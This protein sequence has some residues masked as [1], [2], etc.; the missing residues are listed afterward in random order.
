[1]NELL[2]KL[3]KQQREAVEYING[4]LL[5]LAGAGSGK[6]RVLTHRI[7]YMIGG[8]GVSPWNILAITFTNKAA[9]EMAQ[10]V[11]ALVGAAVNDMWVR[12]FHSAC[13]RILRRD[14]D[15][16]GYDTRFNIIDSDDQKSLVKE[17]I[18]EL[19]FD[20][21]QFPPRSVMSEI[22]FAK[23]NLAEPEAYA[24]EYGEDYRKK[25]IARIYMLYQ[26]KLKTA[27]DLD[28]DDL[29]ML[30]VKL[31]R[32]NEDVLEF[33]RNKFRYILVDEYQD[34]NKA[35]NELVML[36]AGEHRNLCVVGDDDQSIY[37][38]RGADISN[39]L[40]FEK[41]FSESRTVRLEQN[42]RSTQNILDAAN[43]VIKNN[44]G[45]KGKKL[46]TDKGE[47][48]KI[49]VYK[50]LN[51]HDEA[52]F[53][54]DKML[55][56]SAQG[57]SYND[58]AVLYRANASS[59]ALEEVFMRRAVPYRVLS[60]LRFYDRKEI[61]D[62]VAYLRL[63]KNPDDDISLKRII[64]TPSRKIG[65]V[66]LDKIAA[67]AERENCS[68]LKAISAHKEDLGAGVQAF[69]EVI[70][71]LRSYMAENSVSDL[72][73]EVF[74]KTHYNEFLEADEKGE[75]RIDN[76]Y[77]LINGAA[78][79]EENN[80]G[81]TFE[82]YMDNLALISDIDNYDEELEACVFM[83][84]HA[85]KGL[86]FPIVFLC[87]FD[88]GI[89]PSMA[90]SYS[91]E[92]LEEERR[93]CYVGITRAREML[94]I[95]CAR[96]R[97][98]Y[99]KTS[100]YKPSRFLEEIP[101]E[102][103]DI[104][105]NAPDTSDYWMPKQTSFADRVPENSIM[106]HRAVSRNTADSGNTFRPGDSVIHKKFGRGIVIDATPVGNDIHYEIAFESV[107]TKNLLGLYAKLQKCD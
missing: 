94:Y 67:A 83:T 9:R 42:Y 26:K 37:K 33:Y 22:S 10:R 28:F 5:V 53:I 47:G 8:M 39:I 76:V 45:R 93:L 85:A 66:T 17:C 70:D 59:R 34:T 105:D 89:F 86:E 21:K 49:F 1:M 51:E 71:Y 62:M 69:Y 81:A 55:S 79:Y 7:A 90:S 20:E 48:E 106:T 13:V 6:T 60:G 35:Q 16:L 36:L 100:L 82:E 23:D 46:W 61:R 43:N 38:F 88:E 92:E 104:T 19:G 29:I 63:I 2:N 78:N 84:M 50:A 4:P 11:E 65:K 72:V 77:E 87:G 27:N 44:Y 58:M 54:A 68:M 32:E 57:Y 97:M 73:N 74:E 102:L 18:K 30:T 25:Q 96:N 103:L 40:D 80:D 107:G 95:T 14:I 15:R 56:L 41:A 75:E 98:L 64:N 52:G 3:N 99:G 31:F 12:T 101:A 91:S 24:L